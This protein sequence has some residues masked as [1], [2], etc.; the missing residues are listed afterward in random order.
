MNEIKYRKTLHYKKEHEK[1]V[2]W[3]LGG[4][5]KKIGKNLIQFTSKSKKQ[6][7]EM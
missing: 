2:P 3:S 6:E 7:K 4:K 5:R 1:D